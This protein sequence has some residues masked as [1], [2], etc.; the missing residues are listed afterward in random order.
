MVSTLGGST[1]GVVVVAV[2]VFEGVAPGDV[3]FSGVIVVGTGVVPP[4]G[5]SGEPRKTK[6]APAATSK[7]A[8]MIAI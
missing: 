6:N 1:L 4:G 3:V 2:T 7:I 8:T 5:T